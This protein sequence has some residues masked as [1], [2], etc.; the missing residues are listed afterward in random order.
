MYLKEHIS[1]LELE[2]LI[3]IFIQLSTY[4]LNDAIAN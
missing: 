3:K 1:L 4:E 2:K